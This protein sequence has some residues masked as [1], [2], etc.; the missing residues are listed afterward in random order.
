MKLQYFSEQCYSETIQHH[1][2]LIFQDKTR[3]HTKYSPAK[4]I[5]IVVIAYLVFK[6]S[7]LFYIILHGDSSQRYSLQYNTVIYHRTEL[8]HTVGDKKSF[9]HFRRRW[10]KNW[11]IL[12]KN[13][14]KKIHN[15][16]E[17]D[18]RS[19]KKS[20]RLSITCIVI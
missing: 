14:W 17:N 19:N 3:K 20:K 12:H 13:K 10:M 1:L 2:F 15:Y 5:S 16:D 18:S 4:I 7:S 9:S 6:T 8:Q 11:V